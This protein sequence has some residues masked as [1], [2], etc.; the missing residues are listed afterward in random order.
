MAEAV[1]VFA[2][3]KASIRKLEM[4]QPWTWLAKGWKDLRSQPTVGLTY[5]VLAAITG[6]LVTA[7]LFAL[8]MVYLI[9]P[10]MAGFLIIGPILTV[11]IY[12]VSRRLELGQSTTL[13][14]ALGA[15][16]RNLSQ[17]A[18]MGVALM[19]LMFLWARIAALLFFLYFGMDP[20]SFE[21]LFVE[22][23]LSSGSWKFL[24]L[25]TGIG[26]VLSFLA[27]SISVIS[28]PMLLDH[29]EMNVI[30]AIATSFK[31]VQ[32][33]PGAMLLWAGLIVAFSL[34][35]LVTL[36]LGLI[37]TLPLIGHATWHA[38]RDVVQLDPIE[39]TD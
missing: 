14:D 23:F 30:E 24:V 32:I 33:N 28:I 18:L 37:V 5:G 7:G 2:H 21:N 38:Y 17:L 4:D 11:G 20:P 15:F 29:P 25:G 36:Y 16:S 3:P 39:V 1:P 10:L 8:D 19:L 27:F 35:G 26:G 22:T 13:G 34:V 9:L 6:Y 12:E 31:S